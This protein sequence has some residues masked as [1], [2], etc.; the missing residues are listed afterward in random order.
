[1]IGLSAGFSSGF[2]TNSSSTSLEVALAAGFSN[3]GKFEAKL[4]ALVK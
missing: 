1:M 3:E 2:L 4:S